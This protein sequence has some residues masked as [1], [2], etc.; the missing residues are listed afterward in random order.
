MGLSYTALRFQAEAVS[1]I[2]YDRT[3][4]TVIKYM[5]KK[6]DGNYTRMLFAVFEDILEAARYKT[7][8]IQS[9]M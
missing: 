8:A 1:V 2:L 5:E 4:S 3:I 6:L 7:A 9:L